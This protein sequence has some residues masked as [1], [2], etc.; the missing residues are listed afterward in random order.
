MKLCTCSLCQFVVNSK[1]I[2]HVGICVCLNDACSSNNSLT[3]AFQVALLGKVLFQGMF[4]MWISRCHF[5]GEFLKLYGY[6]KN[7][8][9]WLQLNN[10]IY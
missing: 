4:G 7:Y 2:L 1:N 5:F 6:C 3:D 9:N 10:N 8:Y